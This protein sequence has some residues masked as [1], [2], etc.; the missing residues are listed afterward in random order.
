MIYVPNVTSSQDKLILQQRTTNLSRKK[1]LNVPL[2]LHASTGA[3]N[4][5]YTRYTQNPMQ[6]V[7]KQDYA[8]KKLKSL[9]D[10][11]QIK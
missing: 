5:D 1:D 2:I 3:W 4:S 11:M 10:L 6:S 7:P 9:L 8:V